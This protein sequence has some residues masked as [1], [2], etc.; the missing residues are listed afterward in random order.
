MRPGAGAARVACG[1]NVGF[2]RGCA[3]PM[4]GIRLIAVTNPGSLFRRYF[5]VRERRRGEASS[6]APLRLFS[7]SV[8]VENSSNFEFVTVESRRRDENNA[9]MH[10]I[11]LRWSKSRQ[12]GGFSGQNADAF[13]SAQEKGQVTA[14]RFIL[15]PFC[16][17]RK[18][19]TRRDFDH[20]RKISRTLGL[21]SVEPTGFH[22]C[23]GSAEG[24]LPLAASG[25]RLV[26]AAVALDAGC[27]ACRSKVLWEWNESA[28]AS[29][30]F[31]TLL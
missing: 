14:S 11:F 1:I 26:S 30:P 16:A 3:L 4:S 9:Q 20:L 21:P 2:V 28:N 8:T 19:P 13:M 29:G 31:R 17:W 12:V 22:I 7:A 18:A 5:I 23:V 27:V 6:Q 25:M 24:S 15:M 10:E